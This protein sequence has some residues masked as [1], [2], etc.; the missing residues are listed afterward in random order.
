LP[1]E[2]LLGSAR[3]QDDGVTIVLNDNDDDQHGAR[4]QRPAQPTISRAEVHIEMT[5]R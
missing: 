1:R 4:R 3:Q 5:A 2:K